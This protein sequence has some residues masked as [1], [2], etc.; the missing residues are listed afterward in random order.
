MEWKLIG[1]VDWM[2]EVL[3]STIPMRH[4]LAD[5]GLPSLFNFFE[6]VENKKEGSNSLFFYV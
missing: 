6:F 2:Q 1:R 5:V 3:S 4:L